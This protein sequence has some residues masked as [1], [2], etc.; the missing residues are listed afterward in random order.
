MDRTNRSRYGG[1]PRNDNVEEEELYAAGKGQYVY[2]PATGR[3]TFRR[4]VSR[5]VQP[6]VL[7]NRDDKNRG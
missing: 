6:I 3:T 7:P 4:L 1:Y 5:S 2:D